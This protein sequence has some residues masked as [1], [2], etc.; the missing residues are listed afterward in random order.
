MFNDSLFSANNRLTIRRKFLHPSAECNYLVGSSQWS[1]QEGQD[2][3]RM[4]LSGAQDVMFL[5]PSP[6]HCWPT[7]IYE[8]VAGDT[9]KLGD[10]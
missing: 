10:C 9:G 8:L 5:S 6:Q 1:G 3:T 4:E 2:E 7:V